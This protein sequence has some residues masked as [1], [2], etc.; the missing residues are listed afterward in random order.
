[1]TA[2]L[3]NKRSV[4]FKNIICVQ[5]T[6][7]SRSSYIVKRCCNQ[8]CF[9]D[10]KLT[11]AKNNL[12]SFNFLVLK[13]YGKVQFP[14]SSNANQLT[15]F[16]MME[17]LVFNGLNINKNL[18]KK[19]F[20]KQHCTGKS[21]MIFYYQK[22]TPYTNILL[23]DLLQ[24]ASLHCNFKVLITCVFLENL[25]KL[26]RIVFFRTPLNT[27]FCTAWKVS[28]YGVISGPYFPVF[29]PEITPCLDTSRSS[30]Y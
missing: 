12:I 17:T 13:F 15:G 28:K 26:S 6:S 2:G 14:Q 23:R 24:Y 18:N 22:N 11:T 1:M 27:S 4:V 8:A 29:G 21:R 10:L 3:I 30:D 7:F 19:R 25:W 5:L 9:H 16:Y 20:K